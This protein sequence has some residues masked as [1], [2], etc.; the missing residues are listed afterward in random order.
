MMKYAG[1]HFECSAPDPSKLPHP[2]FCFMDDEEKFQ[3]EKFQEKS[4]S[5]DD[6]FSSGTLIRKGIINLSSDEMVFKYIGYL[7]TKHCDGKQFNDC[8]LLTVLKKHREYEKMSKS[9]I[10]CFFVAK[11][12]K[13]DTKCFWLKRTDGSRSYFSVKAC[14]NSNRH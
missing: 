13:Y 11:H 2:S 12:P 7:F 5:N 9:G 8:V 1:A 14:L 10:V 4:N 3:E 6:C